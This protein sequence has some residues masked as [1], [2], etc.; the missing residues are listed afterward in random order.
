MVEFCL[1]LPLFL[2]IVFATIDFGGYFGARL[3]VENAAR[4]GARVAAVQQANSYSAT[5]I[6]SAIAGLEGPAHV[7][8]TTDCVWVGASLDS[9]SYPPF[10]I[11]TGATGCVGIWYFDLLADPTGPPSLCAEWSVQTSSWNVWNTAGQ[12]TSNVT[13]SSLPGGCVAAEEDLVV[14]GVGYHYSTLTPL[15]AIASGAL[16]TYGETQLLEEGVTG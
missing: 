9:N 6:T 10:T 11:P 15:P 12:E 5:S 8:N 2:L 14:V 3:A 16:T 13:Y 4:A 1:V 7:S